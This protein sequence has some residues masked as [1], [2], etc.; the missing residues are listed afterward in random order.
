MEILEGFLDKFPKKCIWTGIYFEKI[1][2]EI[3]GGILSEIIRK[4]PV[5]FSFW[6]IYI[7]QDQHI[8]PNNM[9][10]GGAI[11]FKPWG[12]SSDLTMATLIQELSQSISESLWRSQWI[13]GTF[14][15]HQGLPGE[16]QRIYLT[17]Q[18]IYSHFK[19]MRSIPWRKKGFQCIIISKDFEVYPRFQMILKIYLNESYKTSI[20]L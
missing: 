15:G 17:F 11:I 7:R 9:G 12:T 5:R 13:S 16:V 6:I 18:E 1:S 2:G 14:R 8:H 10:I 20:F 3:I 19:L 4:I